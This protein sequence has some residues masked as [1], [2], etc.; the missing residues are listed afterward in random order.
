MR[1]MSQEK[2]MKIINIFCKEFN[3]PDILRL[4]ALN[5]LY[6]QQRKCYKV[7]KKLKRIVES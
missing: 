6:M 3:I 5:Y 2:L 4:M 1:M 7:Y